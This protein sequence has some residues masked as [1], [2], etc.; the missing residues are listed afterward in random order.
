MTTTT[1]YTSGTRSPEVSRTLLR[2]ELELLLLK[3][4]EPPP[5]R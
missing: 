2:M 5:K 4:R 3:L 1:T